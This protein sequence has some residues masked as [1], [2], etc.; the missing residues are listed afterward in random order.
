MPGDDAD[1]WMLVRDWFVVTTLISLTAATAV[2][3][4]LYARLERRLDRV[5]RANN[6]SD[7]SILVRQLHTFVNDN[8]LRRPRGDAAPAQLLRGA[9]P[10]VKQL[11]LKLLDLMRQAIYGTQRRITE[12]EPI[13]QKHKDDPSLRMNFIMNRLAQLVLDIKRIYTLSI[14]WRRKRRVYEQ[15]IWYTNCARKYIDILYTVE[16]AIQS[17]G[18]FVK[19]KGAEEEVHGAGHDVVI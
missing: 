9:D 12:L 18:E 17:H 7:D 3:D 5:A 13:L 4:K 1:G 11:K 15:T 8:G 6:V 10:P 19:K 14:R 2:A 16:H